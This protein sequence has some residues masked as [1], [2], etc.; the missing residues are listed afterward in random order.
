MCGCA[1]FAMVLFGVFRA[2]A[3]HVWLR[4]LRVPSHRWF[5]LWRQGGDVHEANLHVMGALFLKRKMLRL[6]FDAAVM[7][8]LYGLCVVR[9]DCHHCTYA[10]SPAS[11]CSISILITYCLAGASTYSK[12]ISMALGG[13]LIEK[14]TT[15]VLG[16]EGLACSLTSASLL[17]PFPFLF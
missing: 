5:P 4:Y 17:L 2:L 14:I 6:L 3:S 10:H 9:F 1:W 13:S 7:L 15:Y 8:H 11:E 12:L 16:E